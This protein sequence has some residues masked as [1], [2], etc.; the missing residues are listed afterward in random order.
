MPPSCSTYLTRGYNIQFKILF[1]E[2]FGLDKACALQQFWDVGQPER[3]IVFKQANA[4]EYKSYV[5]H[6]LRAS[7]LPTSEDISLRKRECPDTRCL[8]SAPIHN[9]KMESLFAHQAYAAQSTRAEHNRL[10]GMAMGKASHTFA[11]ETKL[12]ADRRKRFLHAVKSS[13]AR[14]EDW[15]EKHQSDEGFLGLFNRKYISEQ[16]RR[17]IIERALSGRRDNVC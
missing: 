17:D 8:D 12:R 13:K 15:V 2:M 11:C 6:F 16:R 7:G 3:D 14:M 4:A 9:V 10:R 1:K 5:Q